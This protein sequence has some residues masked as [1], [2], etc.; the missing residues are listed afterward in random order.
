MML[1]AVIGDVHGMYDPL[2]ELIA[3]V[4]GKYSEIERW[5]FLGDY[6]DRGPK[7]MQVL[8]FIIEGKLPGLV[9]LKGNHEDMMARWESNWIPNGGDQTLDS[10]G[11]KNWRYRHD[12]SHEPYHSQLAPL[13][14]LREHQ[15][16]VGK[17][18][19]IFED[20]LRIYVHAGLY[21]HESWR[22]DEDYDRLW[23]RN[24]FLQS[25]FDFGKL[26][27]HG[28][29]PYH[30]GSVHN[31]GQKL[32][33]RPNRI[34]MDTASCFGG[35]LS[36]AVFNNEQRLPIDIFQVETPKRM[37]ATEYEDA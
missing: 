19:T 24:E 10:Y 22:Q 37:P 4:Q 5:I 29:T 28:H 31:G 12:D 21:P 7:S 20:D 26:V 33:I 23:I 35:H 17:L 34:N 25:H 18:P 15:R 6:V 14:K 3:K 1:T 36:A 16:W 11:F 32:Q 2:M 13:A 30:S 9:T 8:D 27:V